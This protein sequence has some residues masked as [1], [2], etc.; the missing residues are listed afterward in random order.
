METTRKLIKNFLV[1]EGLDGAG[2]TTQCNLLYEKCLKEN[3][4]CFSTRE[5]TGDTVGRFIRSILK[6]H[7]KVCPAT[8][9]HLFAADRNEHIYGPRG[10][11]ETA[12]EGS[13]VVSDRYFFSSLA[14]Q[15][16]DCDPSFIRALNSPFPLPEFLIY[17]D[18]PPEI[19]LAR[20]EE[21]KDREIYEYLEFQ[22]NVY[23]NY[24]RIIEEYTK[25]PVKVLA[26]DGRLSPESIH[27]E[28]WSFLKKFR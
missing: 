1:L 9:A 14:Y 13:L 19:C 21:R 15:T 28:L 22:K 7:F 25:T 20:L 2:T 23:R 5:P 16:I 27:E 11:L 6:G 4:P 12:A 26:V 10:V 3:I 24:L 8:M 18:V 17:L